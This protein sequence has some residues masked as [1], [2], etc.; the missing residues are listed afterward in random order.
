MF[1]ININVNTLLAIA[2]IAFVVLTAFVL[3]FIAYMCHDKRKFKSID[4]YNELTLDKAKTYNENLK[5]Y[6]NNIE[7]SGVK[8]NKKSK[9]NKIL[10][11][12]KFIKRDSV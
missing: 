6:K 3:I 9:L 8:T 10:R 4:K 1:G 2:I 5:E 12:A 11:I 7:K